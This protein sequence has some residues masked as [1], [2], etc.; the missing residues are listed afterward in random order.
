M[1]VKMPNISCSM[2]AKVVKSYQ[3][4][5]CGRWFVRVSAPVCALRVDKSCNVVVMCDIGR[6]ELE[7]RRQFY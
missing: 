7:I 2:G 3:S 1:I 4:T 6:N 5:K